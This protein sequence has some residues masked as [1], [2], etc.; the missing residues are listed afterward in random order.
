VTLMIG[1]IS[2]LFTGV[3]VSRTLMDFITRKANATLNL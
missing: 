3:F 1:I 2:T